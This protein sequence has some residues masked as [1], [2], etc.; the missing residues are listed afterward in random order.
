MA[1]VNKTWTFDSNAEN[2]ILSL[3]GGAGTATVT[4]D[5]S[6]YL[7]FTYTHTATAEDFVVNSQTSGGPTW[8]TWGVPAGST[9]TSIEITNVN[10]GTGNNGDRGL[11]EGSVSLSVLDTLD[12][13][14]SNNL[15]NYILP[16]IDGTTYQY[17][18]LYGAGGTGPQNV[19]SGKQASNTVVKVEISFTYLTDG[20]V[21]TNL[22]NLIDD[23]S[24]D[25]NYDPPATGT[26]YYLIT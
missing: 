8:E 2:Y 20:S 18:N 5:A 11:T 17:D 14:V 15:L 26:K 16:V 9:V 6:Q 22:I 7:K 10:V 13:A 12:T 25:I 19:I 3:N 23:I 24:L 21:S 4:W 1:T